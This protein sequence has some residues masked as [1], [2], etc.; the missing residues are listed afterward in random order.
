MKLPQAKR[1]SEYIDDYHRAKGE[2]DK[3]RRKI[4]ELEEKIRFLEEMLV[5]ECLSGEQAGTPQ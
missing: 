4:A 1:Q 3:A 5:R 2:L